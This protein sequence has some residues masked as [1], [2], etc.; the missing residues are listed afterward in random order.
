M[1]DVIPLLRVAKVLAVAT[2]FA[3]TIGTVLAR[4]L[5]DRRLF[6]YA[7]AG[8]GFGLTWVCGFGLAAAMEVSIASLW[9]VLAMV[10][11][12][13]SLQVVLYAAGKEGRRTPVVAAL[14]L[15]PLVATVAL[16][17]YRP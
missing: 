16:M 15:A 8:P 5:R 12:L 6:A 10:L 11:S 17:V 14:A 4:D 7:L 9:I 3:G 2:F 13:F 1:A